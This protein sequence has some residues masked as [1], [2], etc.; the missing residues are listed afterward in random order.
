LKFSE[1]E[2]ETVQQSMVLSGIVWLK[3]LGSEHWLLFHRTLVPFL[4]LTWLL[5]SVCDSRSR[6]SDDFWIL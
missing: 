5:T 4:A 6:G 2:W 1:I 3:G